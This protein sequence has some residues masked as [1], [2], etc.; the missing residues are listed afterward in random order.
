MLVT[1]EERQRK[2]MQM[3]F[4]HGMFDD[5][6]SQS[7]LKCMDDEFREICSANKFP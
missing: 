4:H 1:V 2:Q 5:T 7:I 3:Q 6:A